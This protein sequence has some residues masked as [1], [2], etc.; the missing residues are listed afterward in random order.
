[1]ECHTWKKQ[2]FWWWQMNVMIGAS[3]THNQKKLAND[4]KALMMI[5]CIVLC[6]H[7]LTL[8]NHRRR[9]HYQLMTHWLLTNFGRS[10]TQRVWSNLSYHW[11][12]HFV[13][14]NFRLFSLNKHHK[15]KRT[16][17]EQLFFSTPGATCSMTIIHEQKDSDSCATICRI[18]DILFTNI[19]EQD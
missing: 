4:T 2:S 18:I 5:R 14:T 1:M 15:H 12:D 6:R 7:S 17:S 11:F 13:A 10:W 3:R 19:Y 16:S 8:A 9:R